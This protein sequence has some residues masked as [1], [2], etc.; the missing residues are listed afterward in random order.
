VGDDHLP[1]IRR[2]FPFFR[3]TTLAGAGHWLHAEAP[4]LFN[5]QVLTFFSGSADP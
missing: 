2:L 4:K 5:E 1:V 3:L